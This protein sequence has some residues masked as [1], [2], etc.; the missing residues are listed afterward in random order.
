MKKRNTKNRRI[1]K[2]KLLIERCVRK[3]LENLYNP[4][5]FISP[6]MPKLVIYIKLPYFGIQSQTLKSELVNCVGKFFP[7]INLKV[8]LVNNFNIKDIFNH[9]ERLPDSCKSSVIYKYSCESCDAT[10]VGSTNTT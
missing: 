8:I 6:T 1:E 2:K 9:K 7:C 4:S 5:I 10:Y 3:F